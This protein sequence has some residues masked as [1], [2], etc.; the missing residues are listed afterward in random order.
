MRRNPLNG[1]MNVAD[2]L[3]IRALAFGRAA[4][5]VTPHLRVGAALF[6]RTPPTSPIL[7]LVDK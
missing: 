1:I 4:R 5:E 3:E 7:A 6:H 2:L